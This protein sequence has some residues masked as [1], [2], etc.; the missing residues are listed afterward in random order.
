MH[1]FFFD[2]ISASTGGVKAVGFWN[3]SG[4]FILKEKSVWALDD[5]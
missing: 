4:V 3:D 5:T 1:N 2:Q